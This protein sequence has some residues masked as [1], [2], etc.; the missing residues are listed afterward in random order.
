MTS[1]DI[2]SSGG[3]EQQTFHPHLLD[4]RLQAGGKQ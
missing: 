2:A 1:T 3:P 4:G